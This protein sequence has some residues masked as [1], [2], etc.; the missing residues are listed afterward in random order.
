[1]LP[2]TGG[3]LAHLTLEQHRFEL[4]GSSYCGFKIYIE[5]EHVQ[6]KRLPLTALC[7][8]TFLSRSVTDLC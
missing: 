1:M 8:H 4:G 7:S 3:I 2:A 5:E 6:E